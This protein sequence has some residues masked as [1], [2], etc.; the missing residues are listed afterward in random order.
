MD[1]RELMGVYGHLAMRVGS[2]DGATARLSENT[3]HRALL[4]EA[5]RE[6]FPVEK[7]SRPRRIRAEG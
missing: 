7:T 3:D 2:V 4:L 6:D 1:F 5:G